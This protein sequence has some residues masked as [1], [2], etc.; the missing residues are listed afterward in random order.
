MLKMQLFMD[1]KVRKVLID[2]SCY[3]FV[4]DIIDNYPDLKIDTDKICYY[5]DDKEQPI[6]TVDGIC[7][8]SEFDNLLSQ[9]LKRK[10]KK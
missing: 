9:S 5:D 2:Y 8:M 3:F 4:Q 7:F 6:I 1:K 10:N